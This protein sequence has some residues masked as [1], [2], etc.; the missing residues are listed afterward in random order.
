MKKYA[1]LP[2]LLFPVLLTAGSCPAV[3]LSGPQPPAPYGVFST[4]SADSP[5]GGRSAVA[6]TFERA[7]DPDFSRYSSQLALGITDNLE[8]GMNIPYVDNA[9]NGLEDIA[10]TLKHRFFEE[11]MYGPS[12]AYLLTAT[13]SSNNEFL[14]TDGSIG[15]GLV[16]SKRLGPFKGHLNLLY[17]IPWDDDLDDEARFSGG[18]EFAASHDFRLL[19]ELLLRKSNFSDDVDHKELR[20]GYRFL[21]K[22]EVFSTI[23]VGIGLDDREPAYRV[24]ASVS[25]I[26]PRKVKYIERTFEGD[27]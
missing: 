20:V 18:V 25:L 5:E 4:L 11:G 7:G 15:A 3:E 23:G 13:L 10:F 24:M 12:V 22:N 6:F 9:E 26:F 1:F 8:L 19:T 2:A 14:S 27:E 21:Y 17:S 16:A